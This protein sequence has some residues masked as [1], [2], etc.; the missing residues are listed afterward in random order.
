VQRNIRKLV[1]FVGLPVAAIALAVFLLGWAAGSGQKAQATGATPAGLDFSIVATGG[2]KAGGC[3]KAVGSC[4]VVTGG[5]F[6]VAFEVNSLGA[7]PPY[8]GYDTIIAWTGGVNYIAGSLKQTGTGTWE[9]GGPLGCGGP[10]SLLSG[11][12]PTPVGTKSVIPNGADAIGC[13]QATGTT[14]GSTYTGVI[15]TMGFDCKSTGGT[16]SLLLGKNTDIINFS[17]GGANNEAGISESLS[18]A[19]ATPVPATNTPTMTPTA[20]PPPIPRVKKTCTSPNVVGPS[21]NCNVFLHHQAL[22]LGPATCAEG[23]DAA[24]LTEQLNQGVSTINPKG[25]VQTLA[26]FQFEVRY[27]SKSV[28]VFLT[29]SANWQAAI[30]AGTAFCGIRDSANSTL[31]GI[32]QIACGTIGKGVVPA[33]LNIATITVKP[34]PELYSQLRP[35][36]DNGIPVQ[37]LNQDCNLSDNQGHAIPVFSCE[38]ADIT[39]RFLEGD[40]DGPNC[41]VNAF[42][43][44]L[45]AFRW[46]VRKGSTLYNSFMDLSPSGQ[47]KGDGRIDV[48]DLQA[49]FG[50]MGS[51]CTN[52]WPAQL[53]VNPKA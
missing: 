30:T 8:A 13:T 11:G 49:V 24:I 4:T 42:D 3:T 29:P 20:T 31:K 46:G 47:V 28:C 36:Q 1:I 26:A 52:P 9:N 17:D 14:A 21:A 44:Q 19:C 40:V 6:T 2:L 39:F 50:R 15:F 16:I 7:A 53:P 32:A 27:D 38:D 33:G 35:N 25:D 22:K 43:G 23:T 45:I 18:V 48:Q 34:Q 37:I 10:V 51:T 5:Q 41:A 12:T